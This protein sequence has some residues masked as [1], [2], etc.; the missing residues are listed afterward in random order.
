MKLRRVTLIF[1]T[2][3]MLILL[4]SVVLSFLSVFSMFPNRLMHVVSG[5]M[6]NPGRDSI[7]EDDLIKIEPVDER[8][9]ITSYVE[10]SGSGYRKAGS[11]GDV[12]IFHPNGNRGWTPILH[13]VVVWIDFNS[14][15]YDPATRLGGTYDVPSLGL[16]NVM[17]SFT[18]EDYE[19]PGRNDDKDLDIDIGAI[20][21][22]FRSNDLEPHDGFLTKGDDN[23]VIDQ[24]ATFGLRELTWIEPVEMRWVTAVFKSH[25]ERDPLNISCC[26]SWTVLPAILGVGI[27]LLV[28]DLRRKEVNV[29]GQRTASRGRGRRTRAPPDGR[30]QTGYPSSG[31]P[32]RR[33]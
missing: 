1:M 12:L 2:A 31:G 33:R 14:T 15:T 29:P 27:F 20:L 28:L 23:V 18:I 7:N 17:D 6:E 13:R 32:P 5:S 9:E 24:T 8:S 30:S 26:V 22:R 11:Y 3:V 25:L 19:W 16:F 21:Y 4:L 10:G